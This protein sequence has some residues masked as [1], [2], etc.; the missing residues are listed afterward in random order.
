MPKIFEIF[1]Y[2]IEDCS[3]EAQQNRMAARCPFMGCDCDG[4]GNR[5]LSQI[6]LSRNATLKALFPDHSKLAAGVCSIQVKNNTSLW[7]VCPRRLLVLGRE[8]ARTRK[9]QINAEI[10]TLRLLTYPSDTQLGVWPEV[11]LKYISVVNEVEM[12]FDY[13]FD[14]LLMPISSVSQSELES[15][16]NLPWSKLQRLFQNGGYTLAL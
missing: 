5:Y 4:G 2:P 10:E 15:T 13:T 3:E 16:T 12:S 1:G 11:K 14:Y 9:H 7:I 8:R 6:D